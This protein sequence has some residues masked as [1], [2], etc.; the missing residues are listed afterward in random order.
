MKKSLLIGAAVFGL[1]A[2]TFAQ[3]VFFV[4]NTDNY[5]TGSTSTST[6]GGQFWLQTSTASPAVLMASDF[7]LAVLGS[8][9]ANGTYSTIVT[10]L[11]SD[12]TAVGLTTDAAPGCVFNGTSY[13]IPGTQPNGI[14]GW[15][16]LQAWT[17]DYSTY[18][19]AQAAGQ[20][21][22]QSGGQTLTGFNLAN[23]GG[24]STAGAFTPPGLD[25]M[26]AIVLSAVPEP[27]TFALAG[28][29]AAALMIFRRRK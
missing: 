2:T 21:V 16:E 8:T 26:P 14:N 20:Y 23:L 25:P 10:F 7:N 24:T 12:S 28:L 29:G 9:S 1:A 4:D 15:I 19:A 6:S 22:G 27:A 3:G 5:G 13:G 18:A 11:L 17:G